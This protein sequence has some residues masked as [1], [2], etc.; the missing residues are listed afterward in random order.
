MLR[1][2]GPTQLGGSETGIVPKLLPTFVMWNECWFQQLATVPMS[3]SS[4]M[5]TPFVPTPDGRLF[6]TT[7]RLPLLM[8]QVGPGFPVSSEAMT[9]PSKAVALGLGTVCT[10]AP[11]MPLKTR[12]ATASV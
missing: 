11:L 8:R 12:M 7:I 1:A 10:M 3:G 5:R 4:K 2:G 9:G 6:A